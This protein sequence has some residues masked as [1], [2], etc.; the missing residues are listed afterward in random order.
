MMIYMYS[1]AVKQGLIFNWRACSR[2]VSQYGKRSAP[3]TY[4]FAKFCN[5][6]YLKWAS[7]H[8]ACLVI[9]CHKKLTYNNKSA[10]IPSMAWSQ[11]CNHAIDIIGNHDRIELHVSSFN[12]KEDGWLNWRSWKMP[13]QNQFQVRALPTYLYISHE[14]LHVNAYAHRF[15]ERSLLHASVNKN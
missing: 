13:T 9:I 12:I 11:M 3:Y 7:G 2:Q 4:K 8:L 1:C 5:A 10:L 15:S 6:L 14:R